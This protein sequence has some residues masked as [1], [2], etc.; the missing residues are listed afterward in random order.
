[1]MSEDDES[2]SEK[3][4][5]IPS[6]HSSDHQNDKNKE[7]DLLLVSSSEDEESEE[8]EINVK[9]AQSFCQSLP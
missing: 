6:D 5:Y 1:M 9:C 4:E 2:E 3:S 7:S 8:K